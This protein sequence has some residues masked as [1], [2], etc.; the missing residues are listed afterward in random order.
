MFRKVALKTMAL[1]VALSPLASV[2][3][4]ENV[5]P[6]RD[7]VPWPFGRELE[8]PWGDIQGLW[9]AQG[10]GFATYFSLRVTVEK[11]A[12]VRILKIKQLD[13]ATCRTVST[14]VGI[15]QDSIVRAQMTAKEGRTFRV[16]FRAFDLEDS[17]EPLLPGMFRKTDNVMV[18]SVSDVGT[19]RSAVDG[20][21]EYVQISKQSNGL[22]VK[23]C[24]AVVEKNKK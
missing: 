11:E 7:W 22:T 14:G 13:V 20:S 10:E 21:T 24:M 8:F 18:L 2:Y 23:D 16:S 4:Y 5:R 3:A 6:M 15:E 12:G 1:L 19:G 9:K 17:P